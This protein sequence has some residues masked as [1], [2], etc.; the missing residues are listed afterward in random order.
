MQELHK[1]VDDLIKSN[2]LD[3]SNHE[4]ATLVLKLKDTT[5]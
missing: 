3:P 5:G 2:Q 4:V 1:A